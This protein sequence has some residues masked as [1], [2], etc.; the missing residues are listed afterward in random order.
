MAISDLP[1]CSGR[2]AARVLEKLGWVIRSERS[3]IILT[4]PGEP[5]HLSIPNHREVD[6]YLLHQELRKA[7]IS[8][9]E[10]RRVFDEL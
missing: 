3:H 4:K 6:R 8:D 1:L 5:L 2:Q 9:E 7:R 10:F